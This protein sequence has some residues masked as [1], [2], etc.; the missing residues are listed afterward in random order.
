[1]KRRDFVTIGTGAGLVA[2]L[3]KAP[4]V[5]AANVAGHSSQ[6]DIDGA[7]QDRLV[8]SE[9]YVHIRHPK[10]LQRANVQNAALYD[11]SVIE[12]RSDG[13]VT[14]SSGWQLQGR[15][16]EKFK[17]ACVRNAETG[18]VLRRVFLKSKTLKEIQSALAAKNSK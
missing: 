15:T 10:K 16:G 3:S 2:L 11:G 14:L 8:S 17:L 18:I 13:R 4:V 5:F 6:P 12:F 7:V 9:G 1:M